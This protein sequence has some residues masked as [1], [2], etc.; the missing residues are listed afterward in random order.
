[1]FYDPTLVCN[2]EE[3]LMRERGGPDKFHKGR[4]YIAKGEGVTPEYAK[5]HVE[6]FQ[7]A[8]KAGVKIVCGGEPSPVGEYTLLEIEHLVDGDGGVDR[9]DPDLC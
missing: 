6:G 1:V 3:A 2:E 9:R 5:I 8:L 7:K 4:V